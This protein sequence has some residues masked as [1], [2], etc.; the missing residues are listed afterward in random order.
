MPIVVACQCGQRFAARDDLA[1]Q[2][3]RCPACGG[4]LTVPG[5]AAA[6]APAAAAPV[7]PLVVACSCGQRFAARPD[8]AGKTVPCPSCGQPLV[9][10]Q[11]PTAA[12]PAAKAPAPA[13]PAAAAQP[14]VVTCQCG[15]R[16]AAR[17]DLAGK[18]VACPTCKQPLTIPAPGKQA[19]P[20]HRAAA[21]PAAPVGGIGDLLDEI[22]F[23]P[24]KTGVQCTNCKRD[25]QPGTHLCV[26]CGFDH[27][28]GQFRETKRW[29]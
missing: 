8:L 20:T 13:A 1:G 28:A 22:G 27:H 10:G 24:S 23:Q 11:A 2:T 3:M 7:S 6:P 16:F 18:R 14:I 5:A 17:P 19:S 15:A 21:A 9:V 26:H 25:M 4:S 29:R 12:K